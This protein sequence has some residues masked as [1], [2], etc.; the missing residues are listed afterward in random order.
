MFVR[1]ALG[2]D[3]HRRFSTVSHVEQH[4]PGDFRVIKR[5]RREH[6]D[7][8]RKTDTHENR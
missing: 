3:L 4:A 7:R 5:A 2:W 8:E 6:A 1:A